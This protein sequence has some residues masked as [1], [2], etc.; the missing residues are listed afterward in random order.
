MK[1]IVLAA[2]E[3]VRLRPLTE[4]QPKG[5]L[6]LANR[7]I[8]EHIVMQCAQAGLTEFTFV[9][10]YQAQTIESYFQDGARWGVHIEYV[11]QREQLG[12]AH[13]LDSLP[14]RTRDR[15]LVVNG[16]SL[17]KASDIAWMAASED[18]AMGVFHHDDPRHL[19]IVE[20][21]RER[22]V[23]ILE[24]VEKPPSDLANAGLY[25]F[26]PDVFD[27]VARTPKSPRGEYELTDSL[28]MLIDQGKTVRCV[29]LSYWK[30]LT[31]PCRPHS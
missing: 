16:D 12:T 18:M 20:A 19:G 29:R 24:K 8:L 30:E 7:P 27:A 14:E 3:G 4:T 5:M 23:R 21:E 22:V 26:T 31:Y 10:G 11:S 25:L 2:G 28:Q 6:P 13:A 15:F 17:L 9:V 1:A